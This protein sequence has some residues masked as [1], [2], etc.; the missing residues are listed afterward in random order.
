MRIALRHRRPF[1][2]S[3]HPPDPIVDFACRTRRRAGKPVTRG[4]EPG[5]SRAPHPP[6]LIVEDFAALAR[7]MGD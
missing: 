2:D 1:G 7:A 4:V 5:D 6:D 3:P